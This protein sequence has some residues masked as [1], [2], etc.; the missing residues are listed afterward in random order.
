MITQARIDEDLRPAGL[1]WITAL[2]A[3][4]LQTLAKGGEL[5]MSLFARHRGGHLTRLSWREVDC[6]P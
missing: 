5:Q 3:P 1:D 6:L 4:A 2:R